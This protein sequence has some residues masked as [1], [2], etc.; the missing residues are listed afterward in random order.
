V[1]D[2]EAVTRRWMNANG[3][4]SKVAIGQSVEGRMAEDSGTLAT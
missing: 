1:F 2:P 4:D 3:V